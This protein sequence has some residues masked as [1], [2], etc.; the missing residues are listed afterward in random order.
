[1]TPGE[2]PVLR[3][4][5]RGP[6][7]PCIRTVHV[8][9][10]VLVA[11]G[12]QRLVNHAEECHRRFTTRSVLECGAEAGLLVECGQQDLRPQGFVIGL[13]GEFVERFP[14]DVATTDAQVGHA[15]VQVIG[16]GA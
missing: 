8:D 14:G 9:G 12:R 13:R 7:H 16:R 10:E 4:L 1:M 2:V 6:L 11:A 3:G 5:R 15:Q